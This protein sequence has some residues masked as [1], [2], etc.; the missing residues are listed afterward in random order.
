MGSF[1]DD[2]FML[3][4][5]EMP[6]S[7]PNPIHEHL[8]ERLLE[9]QHRIENAKRSL[10]ETENTTSSILKMLQ[11]RAQYE[12]SVSSDDD[13]DLYTKEGQPVIKRKRQKTHRQVLIVKE[14]WKRVV[15]DKWVIGVTL[16]NTSTEQVHDARFYVDVNGDTQVTGASTFWHLVDETF[17]RETDSIS[18]QSE[19]VA[20]VVLN[21]PKFSQE[22]VKTA[23]GIISYRVDGRE[24]Q[25]PVPNVCLSVAEAVNNSFGLEFS[26]SPRES[27]LALKTIS[28]AKTVGID[29]E[30]NPERGA[31]LLQC[32]QTLSFQEICADIYVVEEAGSLMYCLIEILPIIDG[33]AR[34]QISCRSE[35]QMDIILRILED[36]FPNMTVKEENDCVLAATALIQE[37]ESYLYDASGPERQRMKIKSDLLI[38]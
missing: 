30:I 17:Y 13:V 26:K 33:E 34:L 7:K 18:P 22:P 12:D 32:L 3:S 29:I 11:S 4:D 35:A 15:Y 21:L 2:I 6:I 20:A 23:S 1:E 10:E 25:T 9:V 14:C 36:E 38:P 27:I 19:V 5:E 8:T 16:R 24:Y 37:L 31:M 28:V